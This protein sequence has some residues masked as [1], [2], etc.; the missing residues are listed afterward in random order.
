M[1]E[2]LLSSSWRIERL[3]I[4]ARPAFGIAGRLVHIHHVDIHTG[5][6][7]FTEPVHDPAFAF[8]HFFDEDRLPDIGRTHRR[9]DDEV[10]GRKFLAALITIVHLYLDDL[11]AFGG[12]HGGLTWNVRRAGGIAL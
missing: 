3:R 5:G 10:M 9:H 4:V 1:R 7:E 2:R 12:R 6:I 8:I 11:G